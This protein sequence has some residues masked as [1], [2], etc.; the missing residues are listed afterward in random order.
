MKRKILSVRTAVIILIAALAITFLWFDTIKP[1]LGEHGTTNNIFAL[2]KIYKKA[3]SGISTTFTN[4][5]IQKFPFD[6]PTDW[7][8]IFFK[9]PRVILIGKV[10]TNSLHQFIN[11]NPTT[12]F[13]WDGIGTNGENYGEEGWP[14]AKIYS[15]TT[16]TNLF[17]RSPNVNDV[18]QS[19][20]GQFLPVIEGRIEFPSC[21]VVIM[22]Y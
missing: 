21:K 15:T 8:L 20:N 2:Q 6:G 22:S 3:G 13:V 11:D 7:R 10:N 17:F 16:W 12:Q 9:D 14:D 4:S 1:F 18:Q 5:L 19:S